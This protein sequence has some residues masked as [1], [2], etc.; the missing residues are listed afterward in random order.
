ML[1]SLTLTTM[2]GPPIYRTDPAA[3]D[4][5]ASLAGPSSLHPL[6][7]DELGRDL[8][9]RALE[10]GRI[11]IAVGLAVM[12]ISVTV[13]T[14]VGAVAGFFGGRTDQLLMRL[15]DILLTL[16]PLPLLLLVIYLFRDPL[17]RTAG[18]ETG[19][20]MLIVAM[21]G[22]LSWMRIA[23]LVRAS[24]LSLKQQAFVEAARAVGVS[25]GAIMFRH[26][27]PN[28]AGPI[29]VSATLNIGGAITAESVLSFLGLG[30]PPDTP[31]WGRTLADGLHFLELAPH[32]VLV[33]G[34]LIFVTVLSVNYIGDGIQSAFDPHLHARGARQ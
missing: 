30:F 31:T 33:P 5:G 22:L 29:L 8:L 18:P 24:F 14:L 12:L 6:G 17:R 34:L 32:T 16:P 21:I 11:S 28:A 25:A 10:G 2:F 27:L 3:L 9:A 1:L 13:G 15:T 26:M 4:L 19:I 20:F 23:R 7:A